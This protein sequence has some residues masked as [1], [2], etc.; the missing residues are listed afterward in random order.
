MS[1]IAKD[2][3]RDESLQL[4]LKAAFLSTPSGSQLLFGYFGGGRVGTVA[5]SLFLVIY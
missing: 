3:F 4:L 1:P 5:K 2:G